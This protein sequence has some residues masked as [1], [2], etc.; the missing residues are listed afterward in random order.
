VTRT[1]AC[2]ELDRPADPAWAYD[3]GVVGHD[4]LTATFRKLVYDVSGDP[5]FARVLVAEHPPS[6]TIGRHGSVSNVRPGRV[7]VSYVG[8]GGTAWPHGPGQLAIYPALP[9]EAWGVTP[10]ECVARFLATVTAVCH[11]FDV[12][13]RARTDATVTVGLRPVAAVGFAVR[14]GVI[15]HGFVLNVNPDLEEFETV[16]WNGQTMT[17]L[18]RATPLRVRRADVLERVYESLADAFPGLR[19][20]W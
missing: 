4:E 12:P 7:P 17:S 5:A 6:V 10:G 9:L 8:R 19:S 18:A 16:S 11:S 1:I 3:L 2:P 13:A 20:E 14:R 15:V